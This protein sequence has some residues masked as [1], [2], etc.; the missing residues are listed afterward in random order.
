MMEQMINKI[1][2]VEIN[3][4]SPTCH[5]PMLAEGNSTR[6]QRER[7]KG[8]KMPENTV[9]VGRPSKW[10][11][12]FKIVADTIYINVFHRRSYDKWTFLCDGKNID[13][14]VWLYSLLFR[15]DEQWLN[16]ESLFKNHLDFKYWQN[17][18][19]KLDISELKG[20]NLACFC[21]QNL[22]C[23]VDIL[24]EIANQ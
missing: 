21:P 23:H 10:G 2:D 3:S 8:W 11:N 17:H 19:S 9:Y 18:F 24:L 5:K 14:V 20:K 7:T 4:V 6:V 15:N 16:Y 13:Y 12:P 22:A 1:T